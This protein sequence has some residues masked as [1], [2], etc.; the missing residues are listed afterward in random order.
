MSA[1]AANRSFDRCAPRRARASSSVQPR[2]R[3]K[4]SIWNRS[5]AVI[6][7][8]ASQIALEPPLQHQRGVD[9]HRDRGTARS[10]TLRGG[11]GCARGSGDGPAGRA[12]PAPRVGEHPCRD[13]RALETTIGSIDFRSIFG[14]ER[15]R[16]PPDPGPSPGGRSRPLRSPPRPRRPGPVRPCSSRC[17]RAHEPDQ[18]Q[19]V[20]RRRAPRR[21][22]SGHRTRSCRVPP[23]RPEAP[24]AGSSPPSRSSRDPKPR[25]HRSP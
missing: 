7:I 21:R 6:A 24:A 12:G 11:I 15:A 19:P 25:R 13:H 17:R 3:R 18:E 10:R 1:A 4:R 2:A 8:T 23:S 16:A 5:G 9:H 20:A 14:L 22:I